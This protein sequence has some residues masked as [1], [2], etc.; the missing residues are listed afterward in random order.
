MAKISVDKTHVTNSKNEQ[1]NVLVGMQAEARII[2]NE[3]T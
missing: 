1:I 3:T 2:Y